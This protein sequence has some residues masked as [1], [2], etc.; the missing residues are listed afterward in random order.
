MNRFLLSIL[1]VVA[2]TSGVYSQT[3][4]EWQ[5]YFAYSSTSQVAE[6]P[7][8]IFAL[9]DG[10]LF[11]CN[12]NG[13]EI[14]TYS[15]INGLSDSNIAQIAYNNQHNFLF[16]AYQNANI[17][18][19]LNDKVINIPDFMIKTMPGDK[20]I[21]GICFDGDYAYLSTGIGIVVVNVKKYEIQESYT[22]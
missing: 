19:L 14:I 12:K 1:F 8:K 20:S 7:N 17:D 21:N 22:I 18:I 11:S 9:A 13:A 15:K 4:G 2:T 16:I 6:S 10:S 3:I 5:T